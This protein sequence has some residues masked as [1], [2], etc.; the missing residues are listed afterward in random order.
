MASSASAAKH[1]QRECSPHQV[2][3]DVLD[4]PA[5]RALALEVDVRLR[6]VFDEADVELDPRKEVEEVEEGDV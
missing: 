2:Q 5:N 3:Q 1:S 4:R 6:H